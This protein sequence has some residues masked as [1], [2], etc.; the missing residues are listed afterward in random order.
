[1]R[2]AHPGPGGVRLGRPG[3]PDQPVGQLVGQRRCPG[4]RRQLG[5][6][7]RQQGDR[8][9]PPGPARPGPP[10]GP[11]APGRR[12]MS[13]DVVADGTQSRQPGCGCGCCANGAVGSTWC[14]CRRTHSELHQDRDATLQATR[15]CT[16]AVV[17]RTA[18]VT[19]AHGVP[20]PGG[21][22]LDGHE[23]PPG[24]ALTGPDADH[25]AE[26]AAHERGRA[27]QGEHQGEGRVCPAWT[28]PPRT[29]TA[30]R[31]PLPTSSAWLR[32]RSRYVV[33]ATRTSETTDI[34]R[35]RRP[36][37][38]ARGVLTLWSSAAVEV[39]LEP[40]S[41]RRPRAGPSARCRCASA[42]ARWAAS[43]GSTWRA[44]NWAAATLPS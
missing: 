29:S 11:A 1:M 31:E 43:C 32:S 22:A 14:S 18:S 27:H 17:T 24:S 21:D 12:V 42:I 5:G 36:G 10:A 26:A 25:R 40:A 33:R 16:S 6:H 38:D 4:P 41:E 2:R 7:E 9:Q 39:G 19:A 34:A 44:K 3:R 8:E 35:R 23:R 37:G 30:M 13:T 20:A 28:A 15:P